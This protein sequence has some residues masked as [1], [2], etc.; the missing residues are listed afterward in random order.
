MECETTEISLLNP[1]LDFTVSLLI[2]DEDRSL[3]IDN[4]KVRPSKS[5][6]S[7]TAAACPSPGPE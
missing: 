7:D 2:V 6:S 3:S 4:L 5:H 1:V